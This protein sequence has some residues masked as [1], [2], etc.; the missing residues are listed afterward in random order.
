MMRPIMRPMKLAGSELMFG[1]GCLEYI[2]SMPYKKVSVVIGGS[3]MVKS[4]MLDKVCG[5]L[6]ESGA[7]TM[8]IY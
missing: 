1:K 2:K 4:G 5:Y 3:S 7:E 6:K 8:L